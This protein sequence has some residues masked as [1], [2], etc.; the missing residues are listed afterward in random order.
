MLHYCIE[1]LKSNFLASADI[2]AFGHTYVPAASIWPRTFLHSGYFCLILFNKVW[3][4]DNDVNIV[5]LNII[6]HLYVQQK[7]FIHINGHDH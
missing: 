3:S 5:T 2:K 1:L 4:N 6:N 7:S